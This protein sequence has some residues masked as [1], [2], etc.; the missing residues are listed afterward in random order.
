VDYLHVVNRGISACK[1][2]IAL[3]SSDVETHSSICGSYK[4][5][6]L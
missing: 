2:P 3:Y 4:I 6:S 5:Y 1:G